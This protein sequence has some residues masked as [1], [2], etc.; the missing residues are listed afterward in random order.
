MLGDKIRMNNEH[1]KVDFRGTNTK[2]ICLLILF[3]SELSSVQAERQ[4]NENNEDINGDTGA[5]EEKVDEDDGENIAELEAVDTSESTDPV[6]FPVLSAEQYAQFM[7]SLVRLTI[8]ENTFDD[9]IPKGTVQCLHNAISSS[10]K[11][12]D[13]NIV[14][15]KSQKFLR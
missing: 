9:W 12:T 10:A 4:E 8:G 5:G 2:L 13:M 3:H 15:F 14:L 1:L 6:A 7:R 11:L